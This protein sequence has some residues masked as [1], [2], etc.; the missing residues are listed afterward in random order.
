MNAQRSITDTDVKKFLGI[1]D[2]NSDGKITKDEMYDIFK[3]IILKHYGG[4]R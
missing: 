4:N 1:V 2:K 3:E